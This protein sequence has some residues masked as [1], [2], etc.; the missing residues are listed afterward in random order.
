MGSA[1]RSRRNVRFW[2][3]ADAAVRSGRN[4][5][6]ESAGTDYCHPAQGVRIVAYWPT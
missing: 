2:P 3:V 1:V 4:V 6:C 5:S